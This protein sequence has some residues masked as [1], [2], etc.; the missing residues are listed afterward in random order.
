MKILITGG[1]GFI[2]SALIRYII[3]ETE[4]SVVNV[5][6]LTYAGNLDSLSEIE[7]NTRYEFIK[8]DICNESELE[9][10]LKKTQPQ[11][12]MHLAAESH[13]DRSI[14]GP[15]DFIYTNI[16]G[17]Y[18]LLE[19]SRKYWE[20]RKKDLPNFI[21]HHISTDEVFGDLSETDS[22]FTEDSQYKPSS[23]YSA[24]KASSDHLVRSWNRTY[25]IPTVISNCSNNYGP[26]QNKEKF[27]PMVINKALSGDS[28]PVYGDGN[29]IR[30][31]LYVEDHAKALYQVINKA[32]S[33]SSYNIGGNN[34]LSNLEVI[35]KIFS[36]LMFLKPEKATEPDY[37]KNL[38]NYVTDRPG[39]DRRYAI[40]SSKIKKE[41]DWEPAETFDSGLKK[42]IEW[43]IKD[44]NI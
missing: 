34:E 40:D 9:N 35:N 19:T 25:G 16:I 8:S 33:G 5:D 41:L 12:I 21:F 7:N 38:I 31:W 42:T 32:T 13:V 26:Y 43:Y 1:A 28:I 2:G 29:Q 3:E 37:Y 20:E 6:S 30:D 15:S 22:P 11:K 24:S 44:N 17:T 14:L 4:S 39:H 27:I 23:P 10:I 36:N 18:N